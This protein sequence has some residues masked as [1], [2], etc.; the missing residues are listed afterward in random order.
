MRKYRM[1]TL[2]L[3]VGIMATQTGCWSSKEIEDMSMYVGLALDDGKPTATEE[4]LDKQG[5]GY[6]KRN[7]FTAT[8]QI[9]PVKTG[10]N[11]KQEKG[12]GKGDG[13]LNESETGD[14]LIQ[15]M[16]QYSLRRERAV[17]GHHLKVIIISTDLI[18]EQNID[19]LMDF[20]LRDN[21]IRPSCIVLL[22]RGLA[23]DTLKAGNS[24]EI[25]AFKL[26]AMPRGHFRTGEIMRGVNLTRLNSLIGSKQSFMLQEVASSDGETEFS[27]AGIIKGDTGRY[28][29][30]L[31]Q[32]DVQSVS[33]I[34]GDIE[35]AVIKSYNW[36][37]EPMTYELKRLK[38]KIIP[39][40][41]GDRLSFHVHIESEGRIMENWDVDED[42]SQSEFLNRAEKI[43][44]KTL[45]QMLEHLLEK[46]QTKY[47]VDVSGFGK[48][49]SLDHPQYWKKVKDRWDEV[50]SQTPVTF[51]VKFTITDYGS[52]KK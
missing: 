18:R 29:G 39:R 5:E 45:L 37:D 49:L 44:E 14:S 16:R 10:S 36:H 4:K 32:M 19:K 11:N 31:D 41:E 12:Q 50:F 6:P 9:V 25:P 48:Q 46:L 33:W 52:S 20:V 2:L 23:R 27:G 42:P 3:V 47:K 40:V 35:G 1:L 7:L 43:F 30:P 51:D 38:S 13:F 8:V 21:D 26:Q 22:S 17:I 24:E 34:T 28:V 15:L